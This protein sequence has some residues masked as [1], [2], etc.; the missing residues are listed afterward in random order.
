M[1][2]EMDEALFNIILKRIPYIEYHSFN[3]LKSELFIEVLDKAFNKRSFIL[4]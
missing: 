4:H 3:I 2:R 1:L